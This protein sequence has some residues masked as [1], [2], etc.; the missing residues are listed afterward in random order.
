MTINYLAS[1]GPDTAHVVA[2]LLQC[3]HGLPT[4]PSNN[5]AMRIGVAR[6]PE[7]RHILLHRR[8]EIEQS[9]TSFSQESSV[10]QLLL[11]R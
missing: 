8:F 3:A 10:W 1:C 2:R 9:G 6:I 11:K 5:P 4:V 7:K